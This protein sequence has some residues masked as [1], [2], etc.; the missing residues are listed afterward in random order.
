MTLQPL[1]TAAVTVRDNTDL[2]GYSPTYRLD[3]E[4]AAA[5]SRFLNVLQTAVGD[6]PALNAVHIVGSNVEGALIGT[7]V[8]V[9]SSLS[10]GSPASLPF[11]YSV[12]DVATHNHVLVNMSG[13]CAISV[14]KAGGVTQVQVTSGG[15]YVADNQGLIFFQD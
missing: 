7:D 3:E 4:G 8:V 13:S 14:R 15:T 9:F 1:T 5:T 6:P 12:P 11:E 2:P 10:L